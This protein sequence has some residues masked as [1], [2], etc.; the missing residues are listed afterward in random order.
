[1]ERKYFYLCKFTNSETKKEEK[2]QVY[3]KMDERTFYQSK[4]Y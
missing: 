4:T 3:L 2:K 1:M